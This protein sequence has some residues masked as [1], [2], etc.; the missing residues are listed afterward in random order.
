MTT[1]R[2]GCA[3]SPDPSSGV[4]RSVSRC[5]A[6]AAG[7]RDPATLDEAYY[8][9]LGALD[10]DAP[11]R[12]VG[13]LT[14]ALGE[15]PVAP[16][17]GKAM[18]IGCGASPYVGAIRDAGWRYFGADPSPWAVGWLVDQG[19]EAACTGLEGVG[20]FLFPA[21][22]LAAHSLEHMADAPAA[23]RKCADLLTPGGELW[24]IVPDDSDLLNPDHVWFFTPA[25]LRSCLEAAGL[26][27]VR[28]EVRRRVEK[29]LF[30]YARA[31]KP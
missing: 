8:R 25:T 1:H 21:L 3:T 24:L 6:H 17:G 16:P 19:V 23:V 28:L 22:I 9:S 14:E 13:E 30:I 20:G 5:P 15:I 7:R 27:V 18:E 12:Y 10:A 26:A 11:E 31:R 2:C 29:E 4:L